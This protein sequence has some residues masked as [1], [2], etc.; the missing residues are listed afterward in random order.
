L[1]YYNEISEAGYFMKEIDSCFWM[2]K[3]ERHPVVVSSSGVAGHAWQNQEVHVYIL[4][5]FFLF[6]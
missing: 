5:S 3:V 4:W 6:L 1:H 2:C